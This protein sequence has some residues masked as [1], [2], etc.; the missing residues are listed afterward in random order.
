MRAIGFKTVL[1]E[2]LQG[3]VITSFAYSDNGRFDFEIFHRRLAEHGFVIYPGKLS[4]VDCFRI[5][6]A[7]HLFEDDIDALL[8]GAS[9]V[10]AEMGVV[11]SGDTHGMSASQ[12][13]R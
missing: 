5:G 12:G 8:D 13:Q 9:R 4:D 1:P 3:C 11:P 10:A 6:T 7:G 2:A